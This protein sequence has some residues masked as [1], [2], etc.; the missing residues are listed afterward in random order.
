MNQKLKKTEI[1][2]M[3]MRFKFYDCHASNPDDCKVHGI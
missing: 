3:I 2:C 1:F